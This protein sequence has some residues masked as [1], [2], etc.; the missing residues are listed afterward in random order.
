[1]PLC[2]R[3]LGS[4]SGHGDSQPVCQPRGQQVGAGADPVGGHRGGDHGCRV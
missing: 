2:T 3:P 1:M 4:W